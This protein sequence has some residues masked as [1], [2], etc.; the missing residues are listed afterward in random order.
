MF[1]VSFLKPYHE[2]AVDSARGVFQ[3]APSQ[4]RSQV[5]RHIEEILAYKTE[6]ESKKN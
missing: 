5:D 2:D 6:G 3:R 4:I 1:C